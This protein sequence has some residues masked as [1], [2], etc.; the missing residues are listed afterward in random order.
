M[1]EPERQIPLANDEQ[2]E[3]ILVA[4]AAL[5]PGCIPEVMRLVRPSELYRTTH[6]EI[7]SAIYAVFESGREVEAATI[8]GWL[9][10]HGRIEHAGGPRFIGDLFD[11]T[12]TTDAPDEI[13]RRLVRLAAVRRVYLEAKRI[14]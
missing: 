14:Q 2:S 1:A 8:E 7:L 5:E 13:A 11:K 12:P 9:K 4:T 10:D 6:Q 3:R